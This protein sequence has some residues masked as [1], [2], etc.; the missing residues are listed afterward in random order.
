MKLN[1]KIRFARRGDL[2]RIV[3]LCSLHAAYEKAPYSIDNKVKALHTDLF[4][5]PPKLY[6]LVVQS[7]KYL[8][9]YATYM[10]QYSTWEAREYIYMDCLYLKDFARGLVIGKKLINRIQL[11]AEKLGCSTLQWQTPIFNTRAIHFYKNLGAN[12]KQKERFLLTHNPH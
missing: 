11:V 10:K 5:N 8:I 1:V 9:G 7:D 6:C 3:D 12:S 4:S 2:G